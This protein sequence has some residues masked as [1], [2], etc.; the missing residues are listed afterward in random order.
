LM[1]QRGAVP[2][3]LTELL[4]PVAHRVLCPFMTS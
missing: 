3:E 1:Q 4:I 2:H